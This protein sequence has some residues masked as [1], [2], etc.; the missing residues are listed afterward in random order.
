MPSGFV[1]LLLIS[2]ISFAEKESSPSREG[3]R[4][5]AGN[6]YLENSE[7]YRLGG[8]QNAKILREILVNPYQTTDS[9][10][11]KVGEVFGEEVW[12]D[13][14]I[15]PTRCL[16]NAMDTQNFAKTPEPSSLW[17]LFVGGAVLMGVR[18]KR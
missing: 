8:N 17:L 2:S 14:R 18:K 5:S 6:T 1:L 10:K 3:A 7:F 11:V 16:E 9:Q 15:R 4:N 13:P 12:F